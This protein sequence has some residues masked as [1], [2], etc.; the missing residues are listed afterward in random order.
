MRLRWRDE[1]RVALYPDRVAA[2]RYPSGIGNAIAQTFELRVGGHPGTPRWQPAVETLRSALEAAP[3][4]TLSVALS[5]HFARYAVLHWSAALRGTAQ[6]LE[7]ARRALVNTYGQPA[8]HWSVAVCDTGFRKPRIACGIDAELVQ[9][10]VAVARERHMHLVSLRP[11]LVSAFNRVRG[12]LRRRASW[13]ALPERGRLTL[14]TFREGQWAGIRSRALNGHWGSALDQLLASAEQIDSLERPARIA[15]CGDQPIEWFRLGEV[16][17]Y[18]MA[19]PA[20]VPPA[21]RPFALALA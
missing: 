2:V 10:I 20:G 16:E 15:L 19:L 7:Y 4:K 9:A 14:C 1:L 3:S 17:L 21:L 13:L 11:S 12:S 8:L 5:S 18:D 6:W